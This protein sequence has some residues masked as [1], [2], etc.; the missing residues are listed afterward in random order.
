M[1][2]E[3]PRKPWYTRSKYI[4]LVAVLAVLLLFSLYPVGP[5]APKPRNQLALDRAIAYFADNYNFTL[6]LIPETPGSHVYWL[7][8]DNNLADLALTR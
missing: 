6:G 4:V 5:S 1:E 3:S 7:V 8:S 2:T